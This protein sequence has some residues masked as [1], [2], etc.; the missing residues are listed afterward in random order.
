MRFEVEPS[1]VKADEVRHLKLPVSN[2][3]KKD[4]D[5]GRH[6]AP[7]ITPSPISVKAVESSFDP[8]VLRIEGSLHKPDQPAAWVQRKQ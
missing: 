5:P 6:L 8:P 3:S 7:S 4:N 2:G 1:P